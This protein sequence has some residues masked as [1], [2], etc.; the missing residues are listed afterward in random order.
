MTPTYLRP[1]PV[2]GGR[3]QNLV[4]TSVTTPGATLRGVWE[5]LTTQAELRPASPLEPFT[6]D[7]AALASP[8]AEGLRATWLGHATV[9]LDVD[10]CRVLTD[11]VWA[12]Y[13]SPVKGLPVAA[14]AFR[15]FF[16]P[17]LPLSDVPALDAVLLSH[18]HYDHFDPAALRALAGRTARFVCPLGL[19]ATLRSIGV[20]A[21]KITELDW[22]DAADLP[23]GITVTAL[24][25]RHFS[26]RGLLDANRTLWAAY[27]LR[28]PSHRV[29]VGGDS[30]PLPVLFEQIGAAHG[31]FDLTLLP[32]GAYDP[33]APD[34]HVTPEQ[35]VAAHEALGGRVLLP[36]HW[37]TFD[38]S[39]HG[40][41][42]PARRVLAAAARAEVP[43]WL[44]A[45]GQ[46][47]TIHRPPTSRVDPWWEQT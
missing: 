19:G 41:R 20:P 15:R 28:G 4:P 34:V 11:P 33:Y 13:A 18:D 9:L 22:T 31:P 47:L 6:A 29:F 23:G 8:P 2:D 36:V 37:G 12:E 10:G 44:P 5:R 35:A 14:F 7:T 16:A 39:F 38:L 17:P 25:A 42:E 24:P 40:W 27:A 30:G 3:F 1:A 21:G 26:G 45:P 43:L 46:T 32:I